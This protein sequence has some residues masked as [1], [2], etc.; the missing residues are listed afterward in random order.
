[1]VPRRK[2]APD[3]PAWPK[4]SGSTTASPC[5]G[6]AGG[7]VGQAFEDEADALQWLRDH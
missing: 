4:T 6:R 3:T 7:L 1:M 2:P 5:S